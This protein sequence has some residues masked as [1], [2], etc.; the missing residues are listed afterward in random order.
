MDEGLDAARQVFGD[1]DIKVSAQAYLERFYR[2]LGFEVV[3]PV[4]LEDGI[5]HLPMI[6]RI[7]VDI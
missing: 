7:V 2:S 3:G 5:P 6:R 4:Y 1:V